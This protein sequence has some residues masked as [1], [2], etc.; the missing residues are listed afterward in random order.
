MVKRTDSASNWTIWDTSR[1]PYNY[2]GRSLY[3]NL[4]NAEDAN[5]PT[6]GAQVIDVLSNGFKLRDTGGS[7]Q[8]NA[9]GGTYIWASFAEHPFQYARAR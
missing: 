4:S 8:V 6:G 9:S 5:T 3:P 7:G 2:A 1:D